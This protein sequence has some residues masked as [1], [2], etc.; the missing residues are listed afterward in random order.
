[1]DVGPVKYPNSKEAWISPNLYNRVSVM[2]SSILMTTTV[3][4]YNEA[5]SERALVATI[6]SYTGNFVR[7]DGFGR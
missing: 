4:L 3:I 5:F 6:R 7:E 1:V 2:V